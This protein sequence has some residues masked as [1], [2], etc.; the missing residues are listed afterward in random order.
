MG[1]RQW[2]AQADTHITLAQ[3]GRY[4][5]RRR[6][7]RRGDAATVRKCA[8]QSCGGTVDRPE[9]FEVRGRKDAPGGALLELAVETRR[10]LPA[11]EEIVAAC[12]QPLGRGELAKAAGMPHDGRFRGGLE[13]AIDSGRLIPRDDGLYERPAS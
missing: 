10:A 2:T 8:C 3:T 13:D 9:H 6:L 5:R 12:D 1:G 11:A 4:A 7:G